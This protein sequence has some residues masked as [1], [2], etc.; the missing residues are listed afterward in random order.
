MTSNT[1]EHTHPICGPS[2][3]MCAP[4]HGCPCPS[5]MATRLC[6]KKVPTGRALGKHRV[7]NSPAGCEPKP[8]ASFMGIVTT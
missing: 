5:Q 4:A 6:K 3:D 7:G 8:Q 1:G 2:E